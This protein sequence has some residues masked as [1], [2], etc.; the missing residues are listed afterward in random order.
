AVSR[1]AAKGMWQFVQFRGNQYGLMQTPYSDDRYDPEKATRAAARHLHDLYNEFHDWYLAIAAYNCGPG[2][3]E[4]A[5]EHTGYAD[6]WELRARRAIPIETSNYVPII[7]AMTIMAKNAPEYGLDRITPDQP[8]EY[9]TLRLDATTN[10]ALVGDL[11]DTPLPELQQLNPALLRGTA[12][13]G[14][15]LRVPKGSAGLLG[16]ALDKVP[17]AV[18]ANSRMHRVE[19]GETLSAIARHYKAT[20][21]SIAAVN[22]L[23]DAEPNPGDQILIPAAYHEAPPPVRSS[24]NSRGASHVASSRKPATAGGKSSAAASRTTPRH[25]SSGVVARASHKPASINR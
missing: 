16:V 15:D 7:L 2:T 19:S 8:L 18:R 4:K 24:R 17:V 9:D 6:Y 11:T 20:E 13:S 14:Y 22:N 21:K 3:I 5:V 23:A 25:R 10:L 1:A 12:P